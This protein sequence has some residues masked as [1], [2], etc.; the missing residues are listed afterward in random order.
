MNPNSDYLHE[1]YNEVM[2]EPQKSAMVNLPLPANTMAVA[3]YH[4]DEYGQV[5]LPEW[6]GMPF[7]NEPSMSNTNASPEAKTSVSVTQPAVSKPPVNPFFNFTSPSATPAPIKNKSFFNFEGGSMKGLG[8]NWG[9]IFLSV[10]SP[11]V[12]QKL[13][14]GSPLTAPEVSHV[15]SVQ[16]SINQK[17]QSG[18]ALTPPENEALQF[19][20]SHPDFTAPSGSG[21]TNVASSAPTP[22]P[23]TTVSVNPSG[24]MTMPQHNEPRNDR[25]YDNL[26]PRP[27]LLSGLG[28]AVPVTT[29]SGS[30][31]TNVAS[32]ALTAISSI[33]GK[34]QSSTPA[35]APAT[36]VVQQPSSSPNM[37][38]YLV[39]GGIGLGVLITGAIVYKAVA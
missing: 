21:W 25:G 11:T 16:R 33:F 4:E 10:L 38:K 34:N 1:L 7:E 6:N 2:G 31:W 18:A 28:D 24:A 26:R 32:S 9:N 20:Y 39:Y 29:D 35:P 22:A 19:I 27:L 17:V 13:R 30:G 15:Q 36:V 3:P 12:T 8:T 14:T 5:N 37:T 23:A